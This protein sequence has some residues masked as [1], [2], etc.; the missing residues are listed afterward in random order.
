[1]P[2]FQNYA[3]SF[4]TTVRHGFNLSYTR[5]SLTLFSQVNEAQSYF[6]LTNT[7]KRE[8]KKP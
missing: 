2:T 1:M 5:H 4:I 3:A 7:M 8:T 6:I